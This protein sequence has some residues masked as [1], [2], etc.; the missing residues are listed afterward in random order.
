MHCSTNHNV[1]THNNN[2][3]NNTIYIYRC[4]NSS[5]YTFTLICALSETVY[6][7]NVCSA[8]GTYYEH[9][10]GYTCAYIQNETIGSEIH[11]CCIICAYYIIILCIIYGTKDCYYVYYCYRDDIDKSVNDDRLKNRPL[12]SLTHPISQT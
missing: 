10:V 4:V 9:I 3:H 12:P 2:N 6:G 5:G 8:L 7:N 11:E 1:F